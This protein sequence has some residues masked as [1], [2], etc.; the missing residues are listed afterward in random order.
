MSKQISVLI[1]DD[2]TK[3]IAKIQNDFKKEYG[4]SLSFSKALDEILRRTI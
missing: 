2:L 3:E 1:D 4:K